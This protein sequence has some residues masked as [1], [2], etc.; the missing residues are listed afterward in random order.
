MARDALSPQAAAAALTVLPGWSLVRDGR[1][2]ARTF[3]F[4]SFSQAFAFMTRCALAAEKLDHHPEW[5]NV[6]GRVDVTLT[7]HDASGLTDLDF[8]LAK[9]MNRFTAAPSVRVVEPA[10]SHVSPETAESREPRS[11]AMR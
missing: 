11:E 5:S 9:Q 10:G 8:R 6:Y 1:A 4:A 7:T 3:A 2:I